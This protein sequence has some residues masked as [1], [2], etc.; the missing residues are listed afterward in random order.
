MTWLTILQLL[1]SLAGGLVSALTKA[2]AAPEVIALA[3]SALT[4]LQQ[5]E[6]T[7]VT[8]E[9]LDSVRFTPQW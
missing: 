2:G 8:K 9:Q 6:G 3:E 5:V 7:P 4:S 1:L